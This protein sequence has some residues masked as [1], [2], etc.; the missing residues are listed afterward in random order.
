[1]RSAWAA[2]ARTGN[3]STDITGP[4]PAYELGNRDTMI[5]GVP[6]EVAQDPLADQR[7]LWDGLWSAD[8]RAA[9]FPT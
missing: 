7:D 6:F 8:C 3:P 9:G 1:M 2:F 4:W 5:L